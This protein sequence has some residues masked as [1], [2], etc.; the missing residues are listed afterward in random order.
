MSEPEEIR[1]ESG[2]T[3]R[4]RVPLR[5]WR[6][7]HEDRPPVLLLHGASARHETFMVPDPAPRRPWRAR[8]LMRWLHAKGF[9]PWLLDWRGSGLVVDLVGDGDP[10]R[11][12]EVGDRFDFDH[13]ARLDVP[14]ALDLIG[15]ETGGRPIS[16]VGHC[17]G[18]AVLAQAIAAGHA[19][20]RGLARVVLLTLG[21]FYEP[22]WDGRLKSQDY[23]LERLERL[24]DGRLV[25]VDPRP[26]R[27]G[28]WH[29]ELHEI[30]GNWPASLRP[31]RGM[32]ISPME[33]M[34]NR[35]SFMYGAPYLERNLEPEFHADGFL[36]RQFGAIPLRMY[37]HGAQNARRG[38][39]AP[40]NAANDDVKLIAPQAWTRFDALEAV[41]LITGAENQLWHRDS[42]DRMYEWLVGRSAG[43]QRHCRVRKHVLAGYGHQDLLWGAAAHKHVFPRILMGLGGIGGHGIGGLAS[44][45]RVPAVARELPLA[46]SGVP[47][48]SLLPR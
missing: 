46:A 26:G 4:E 40:F 19:A 12:E 29:P 17:M 39:A 45:E 25:T 48:P 18:A 34:C 5:L 41:T 16:A 10:A 2:G 47:A 27:R 11:L 35:V 20:D 28:G 30:Y 23:V 24:S 14:A 21:L 36:E 13:A 32:N 37:L 7:R 3:E 38:W 6:L 33:R 1:F 42:I 15:H 22:T 8:C 9:E 31:H 44:L 43:Q